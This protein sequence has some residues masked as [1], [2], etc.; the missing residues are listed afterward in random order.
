MELW[1]HF[2]DT[3][4]DAEYRQFIESDGELAEDDECECGI[5]ADQVGMSV[6][7]SK[8]DFDKIMRANQSLT[9]QSDSFRAAAIRW[10]EQARAAESSRNFW[11]VMGCV[12]AAL[13]LWMAWRAA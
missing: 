10:C 11:C 5:E 8:R 7:I 2:D 4:L 9:D 6:M 12:M 13:A 1:N 3:R